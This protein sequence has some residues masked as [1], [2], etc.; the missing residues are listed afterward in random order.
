MS[1]A[2]LNLDLIL[3]PAPY[4]LATAGFLAT[5]ATVEIEIAEATITDAA[6]A[7]TVANIQSRLTAA[8]QALEKQRKALKDPFRLAG[9]AIDAAARAP[10][11]RI[12]KA[13]Q[14]VKSKLSA[15][16]TAER[17]KAAEAERVRQLEI[18]RLAKIRQAEIDAEMAKLRGAER[19]QREAAEAALK[20]A[21]AAV[22]GLDL[23]DEYP[24]PVAIPKTEAQKALETAQH[25]PVVVA[26][27]PAGVTFRVTLVPV[28][29][30]V[31][32]LPEAFVTKEPKMRALIST[33]CSGW[34]E[35]RALPVVAG[36]EFQVKREPVSSGRGY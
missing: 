2:P 34:S 5:L 12:E 13:K 16:D 10:A 22:A 8:G 23:D 32:L 11:D 3:P 24:E 14:A 21:P 30:D 9:E 18:N 35:G 27:K 15:Y 1:T 25:A 29:K 20:N 6:S 17:A 28:V 4:T 19:I 31:N 33:F 36:V 26:P 7:Q